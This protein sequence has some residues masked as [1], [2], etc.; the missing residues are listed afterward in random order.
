MMMILRQPADKSNP[1]TIAADQQTTGSL[2]IQIGLGCV[3]SVQILA[4]DSSAEK[5]LRDLLLYVFPILKQLQESVKGFRCE[6]EGG[7]RNG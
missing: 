7:V 3:H 1:T 5:D 4:P 2:A 6:I